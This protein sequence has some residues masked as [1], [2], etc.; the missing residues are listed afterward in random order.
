LLI[1]VLF[2][3]LNIKSVK[4]YAIPGWR[5]RFV[6][7]RPSPE[8][9]CGKRNL[10]YPIRA[11]S[12]V[13]IIMYPTCTI[14][15]VEKI[16]GMAYIFTLLMF[17]K[18]NKTTINKNKTTNFYRSTSFRFLFIFRYWWRPWCYEPQPSPEYSCGKR[19]PLYPIRAASLV[20]I[21]LYFIHVQSWGRWKCHIIKLGTST[22]A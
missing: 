10:L 3:F 19:S 22:A 12:F 4:I 9:E 15:S 17:R 14:K 13:S 8:Y 11:N 16:Y 21:V 18:P 1:V 6:A 20:S 5:L 7:P 2:G